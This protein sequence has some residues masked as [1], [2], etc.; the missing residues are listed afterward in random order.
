MPTLLKACCFLRWGYPPC[1]PGG[2]EMQVPTSAIS[3]R[4]EREDSEGWDRCLLKSATHW[5]LPQWLL[6]LSPCDS[7]DWFQSPWACQPLSQGTVLDH[8]NTWVALRVSQVLLAAGLSWALGFIIYN[9]H[10]V[11]F[12]GRP[13][14]TPMKSRRQ[15]FLWADAALGFSVFCLQSQVSSSM[16]L[17]LRFW[18]ICIGFALIHPVGNCSFSSFHRLE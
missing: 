1:S 9:N 17:H 14:H 12:V 18:C 15:P 3:P 11:R 16:L 5:Q 6:R 7:K 10:M 2:R 8:C 13:C 4:V